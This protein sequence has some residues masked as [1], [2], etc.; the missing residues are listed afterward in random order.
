MLYFLVVA[1]CFFDLCM[2]ILYPSPNPINI[3]NLNKRLILEMIRFTPGGISR[4]EI[5]RQMDLTRAAISTIVDDFLKAELVREAE[6]GPA[7][8]GRRPILLEINPRRGI[9][10]GVDVGATHLGLVITDFNAHVIGDLEVPFDIRTGPEAALPE[11]DNRLRELAVSLGC[12]FEDVLAVGVGVPG[13]VVADTGAVSAPPIM[14]GWDDF[15]IRDRLQSLWN[16]P[17]SLNN[18]AELGALGEWAYGAGRG[19]RHLAYIKVGSG[20]GAGLLLDGRIYRG[21]T[22]CAGEIGHI[23]LLENGPLCSC[24]NRGCLEAIAGGAAIARKAQ[25]AVRAGRRTQLG[26]L[27]PVEAI[28]AKEVASAA[29]LGDLVSQQIVAEAGSY[30]GIAIAGVVNLFNPGMI[31]VG[32]GI[33]QMGDLLLEPLRQTVRERSLRSAAQAVRITSAM[34]GRR[35]SGMGAIVQAVNVALH[36]LTEC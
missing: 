28:T 27:T 12:S 3:K 16:V 20:V 11:I 8:G 2:A 34:L 29:R 18:D 36:Q 35:S 26:A 24:G 21:V 6:A 25:E 4:A 1:Y 7:T 13:P 15:P 9:V 32:G 23:T 19:E 5:A 22:G 33:S 17:V 30:L 14:P 31:I 10:A